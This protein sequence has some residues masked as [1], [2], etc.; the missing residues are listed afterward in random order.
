MPSDESKQPSVESLFQQ[1]AEKLGEP[2]SSSKAPELLSA[3]PESFLRWTQFLGCKRTYLSDRYRAFFEFLNSPAKRKLIN[4]PRG[5]YKSTLLCCYA[6]REIVK[7]PNIR[8]LY[9]SETYANSKEYIAWIR[10]QFESNVDL[11]KE[12]GDFVGK[13]DWRQEKFTVSKRTDLSKKEPTLSASGIDVTKT[14]MHY[15]VIIVDDPVSDTNTMTSGQMEKTLNWYRLL[16]SILEPG[17]TLILCGTRYDDEDLYGH[18]IRSNPEMERFYESLP[19]DKRRPDLM[20]YEIMVEKAAFEEDLHLLHEGAGVENV[21]TY[22]KHLDGPYLRKQL[23]IQGSY[24]WSCQ[25]QNEP[26]SSE[27]AL[28]TREQFRLIPADE[29]PKTLNLYMLTDSATTPDGCHSCIFILGKDT[30]NNV[31]ILDGWSAQCK[32]DEYLNKFFLYWMK[33]N[34]RSAGLEKVPI[35]DN[36]WTM[37]EQESRVRQIRVRAEWIMGRTRE[38]KDDRIISQQTRFESGT[39]FFSDELDKYL[40]HLEGRQCFG[41]IVRQYV[42]FRPKS[43]GTKDI[44]D[45]LSDMDKRD[46]RTGAE[47]FPYP[48]RRVTTEQREPGTVNGTF[49]PH[50]PRRQP[51]QGNANESFWDRQRRLSDQRRS[52]A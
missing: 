2:K 52:H 4:M 37:I 20:P 44:P 28:F 45:C 42:R 22:F 46:R 10:R 32:P 15:D 41:E 48:R 7:N 16:L 14:G 13:T 35:N 39:I 43:G 27:N 12:F 30:I 25:Y 50:A 9:A 5:T 51:V 6:A 24:V 31:Y 11:K 36:Y 23:L 21:R 19:E 3:T 18:I 33:W 29:I 1:I 47:L 8:I 49:N 38:S 34:P 40:I 17:G 26:V